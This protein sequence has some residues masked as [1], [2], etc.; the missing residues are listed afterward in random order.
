V[1][2]NLLMQAPRGRERESIDRAAT[3][4]PVLA[5]RIGQRVGTLSGGE[6]Q[7]LSMAAVYVRGAEVILADELSLGLA[8]MIIDRIFASVQSLAHEGV[9]LLLVDQFVSQVLDMA[10]RA[11]I[12]RHGEVAFEGAASQASRPGR[13]H[14]LPRTVTVDPTRPASASSTGRPAPRRGQQR[15]DGCR[16]DPV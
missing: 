10:D 3:A 2:E 7:M 15:S 8:P 6:Q 1:R 5:T 16:R 11:Y 4:F 13:L 12:L 14:P 9:A